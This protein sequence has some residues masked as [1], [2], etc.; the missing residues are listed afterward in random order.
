MIGSSGCAARRV[1]VR[2][3]LIVGAALS[4]AALEVACRVVHA[5]G[6]WSP[7][8]LTGAADKRLPVNVFVSSWRLANEHQTCARISFSVD[9]VRS[10]FMQRATSTILQLSPNLFAGLR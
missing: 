8:D 2:H 9:Y 6:T 4:F 1:R 7:V 10:S 5:D 3:R